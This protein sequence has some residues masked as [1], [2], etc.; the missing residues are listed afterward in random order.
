LKNI[1]YKRVEEE[2]TR[3]PGVAAYWRSF[4][5]GVSLADRIGSAASDARQVSDL[6]SF[7]NPNWRPLWLWL[8]HADARQV[9]DLPEANPHLLL[10]A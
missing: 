6:M 8:C 9:S 7:F 3:T 2:S 1:D 10:R 4:Q 5:L